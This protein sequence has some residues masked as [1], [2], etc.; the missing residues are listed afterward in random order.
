MDDSDFESEPQ[1]EGGGQEWLV[2]WADMVSLLLVFFMVLQAFSTI[3][4][5][6]FGEAVQ[7]IQ[8]AFRV[9]I[10]YEGSS[11]IPGDPDA[12]EQMAGELEEQNVEGLTVQQFG[13]RLV[14]RVDSGLLFDLGK[15]TLRPEA[16][17]V[18]Q[19]IAKAL[20]G[21]DGNVRVEGHTCNL[22]VTPGL[23][24]RDNWD[25]SAARALTVV[26]ALVAQGI[27]PERLGAL[28]C[29]EYRPLAPNDSEEH[30]R[31]NRRVEFVVEKKVGTADIVG[32]E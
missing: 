4:E 8:R 5:K 23:G 17:P 20:A 2:T 27:R 16:T 1:G 25:L 6:K 19:R 32:A 26:E 12:M 13:D 9:P 10:S 3:S 24:F 15:A 21:V 18:M 7:S 29:G 28:A 14:L 30:R 31:K 11:A 22:P